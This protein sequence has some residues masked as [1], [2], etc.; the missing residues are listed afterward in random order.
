M[1]AS[2]HDNVRAR[3]VRGAEE[4]AGVAGNGQSPGTG[5][6]AGSTGPRR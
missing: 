5:E 2:I 4:R 6:R 1:K 3:G